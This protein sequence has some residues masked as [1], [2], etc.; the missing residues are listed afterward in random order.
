M[1]LAPARF[2]V[3]VMVPDVWD[4]VVLAVDGDTTV[5]ALKRQALARAVVVA[6]DPA[7]YLVKFRG[8]AVLDERLTLADLGVPANAALIVL[9]RRRRPVR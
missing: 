1:T 4:H 8:A 7:E 9:P 6:A 2:S 3:R 5:E